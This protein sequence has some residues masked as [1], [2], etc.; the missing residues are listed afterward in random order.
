MSESKSKTLTRSEFR[1]VFIRP[2]EEA[3]GFKV[4]WN[5]KECKNAG[6]EE[7]SGN[8]CGESYTTKENSPIVLRFSKNNILM[9]S[10]LIHEIAHSYLHRKGTEGYSIC[11]YASEIE[12][13]TV[14]LKVFNSM[15]IPLQGQISYIQYHEGMYYKKHNDIYDIKEREYIIDKLVSDIVNILKDNSKIIKSLKDKAP[16][17]KRTEYKYM[18][19]CE[20]CGYKWYYKRKCKIVTTNAEGYWCGYCGKEKSINELT[21][22]DLP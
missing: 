13:E 11:N 21:V 3:F 20:I 19:Q 8:A 16:T 12:A 17:R 18:V 9:I 5:G 6:L 4:Y 1:K 2:L 22:I 7:L 10:S 14:S 15:D